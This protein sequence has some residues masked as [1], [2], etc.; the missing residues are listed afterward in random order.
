MPKA[1]LI[2]LFIN[3]WIYK[4]IL[5]LS[6]IAQEYACGHLQ[7]AALEVFVQKLRWD[8]DFGTLCHYILDKKSCSLK[9]E[10][11]KAVT[12]NKALA[13]QLEQKCDSI[14]KSHWLAYTSVTTKFRF[15]KIVA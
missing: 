14:L 2:P 4:R 1:L 9:L 7:T 15:L 11:I 8:N 13:D 3:S 10:L 6:Q 12:Q 5:N